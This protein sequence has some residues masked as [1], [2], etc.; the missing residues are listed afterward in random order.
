ML[1]GMLRERFRSIDT[2]PRS[3]VVIVAGNVRRLE[4]WYA[5]HLRS[6]GRYLDRFVSVITPCH[7]LD[8]VSP[9]ATPDGMNVRRFDPGS[10]EAIDIRYW[11]ARVCGFDPRDEHVWRWWRKIHWINRWEMARESR[12]FNARKPW[13]GVSVRQN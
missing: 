11:E 6:W 12:G 4:R 1:K 2:A 8:R 13:F 9:A 10:L 3:R 7:N 5:A